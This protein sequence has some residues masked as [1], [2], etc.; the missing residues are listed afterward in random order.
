VTVYVIP[1][2]EEDDAGAAWMEGV[3]HEWAD[4]LADERQDIYTLSDGE[5]VSGP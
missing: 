3:L 1:A 5:P 2:L 4:E